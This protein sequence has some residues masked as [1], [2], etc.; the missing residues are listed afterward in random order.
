MKKTLLPFTMLLISVSAM[1]HDY[2]RLTATELN[3]TETSRRIAIECTQESNYNQF[4]NGGAN[5]NGLLLAEA[6]VFEWVSAGE[7]KFY[8][9]KVFADASSAYLQNTNITTFGAIDDETI[10][11]FTAVNPTPEGTGVDNFAGANCYYFTDEGK[12]YLVRLSL[13]DKWFN[14]NGNTYNTGTGVWTVQNIIDLN[15]YYKVTINIVK[16][17]ATTTETRILKE[18][19]EITVPEYPS[20]ESDY[21]TTTKTA[22]DDQA[23]TVTYTKVE[24][25]TE[26]LVDVTTDV[27]TPIN[28]IVEATRPAY[29]NPHLYLK[30][31]K[32][33][34]CQP[35]RYGSADTNGKIEDGS[36][37]FYFTKASL[38]KYYIH[39]YEANSNFVLGV[40]EAGNNAV[41]EL[42]DKTNPEDK[43]AIEWTLEEVD[44]TKVA[45]KTK[46][47]EGDYI[48][49]DGGG[50]PSDAVLQTVPGTLGNGY[51][52][53]LTKPESPKV[54][55]TELKYATFYAPVAVQIPEGLDAYYVS[56]TTEQ[57]AS[58]KAIED[59]IPAKT[60][61]VLYSET[62]KS[63]EFVVAATVPAIE[64]NKL[65]GTTADK[66]IE[67][68][69]YVLASVE[70]NV[71][72]YKAELN[73]NAEGAEGD[74]HFLNNAGKA[75]LPVAALEARFLSFDFG[76]ETAIDELKGENGNVKTVIYDLSGRRV[77]KAQKGMY[78]VNGKKVVK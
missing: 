66:Y 27:E 63:Y 74:S 48:F 15:G 70:G 37:L 69:A 64:S 62:A 41:L 11:K 67:G 68:N 51:K 20:Y 72:F 10:A 2:Q 13:G 29:G 44:G 54:D 65:L 76:T 6:N 42:V 39:L 4:Y 34:L 22:T 52:F 5:R 55:I 18:G 32:V 53:T 49:Y 33:V 7:G 1:A 46:I 24:T 59:V 36:F 9:K 47:G 12:P 14:F 23:I 57:S 35:E 21:T 43:T 40:A 38:G 16:D 30:D 58:M 31:G 26:E 17:G 45:F 60:G 73:K 77:Q 3:A 78:I 56:A 19:E 8:I 25:V 61:V 50:K 28:Y 75:Y 71:G